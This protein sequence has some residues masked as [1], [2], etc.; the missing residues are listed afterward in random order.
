VRLP[1]V[2]TIVFPDR[3]SEFWFTDRV[4]ELGDKLR[5]DGESWL[6]TQVAT[7]DTGAETKPVVTVRRD[8]LVPDSGASSRFFGREPSHA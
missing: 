5:H 4:F 3:K 1:Q 7:A 8:G 6:V 2:I